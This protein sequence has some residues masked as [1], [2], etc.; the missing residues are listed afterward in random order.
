M[1]KPPKGIGCE[2]P[3]E[4]QSHPEREPGN[5]GGLISGVSDIFGFAFGKVRLAALGTVDRESKHGGREARL[6]TIARARRAR[7]KV[8]AE[9]R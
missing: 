8:V 6:G 4:A 9:G 7:A 2:L 5:E 3:S 1:S